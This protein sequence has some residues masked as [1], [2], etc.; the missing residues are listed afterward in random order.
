MGDIFAK[1]RIESRN[2]AE[3]M[4]GDPTPARGSIFRR[5]R[6]TQILNPVINV[7]REMLESCERE[8]HREH[9][10]VTAVFSRVSVA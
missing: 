9:L 7:G 6:L 2:H 1:E 3:M 4:A 10:A 5:C 8:L